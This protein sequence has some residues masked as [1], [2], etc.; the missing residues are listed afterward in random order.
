MNE[1]TEKATIATAIHV[2]KS[3]RANTKNTRPEPTIVDKLDGELQIE[4]SECPDLFVGFKTEG[5]A[6]IPCVRKG[7]VN[8]PVAHDIK[9]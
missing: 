5:M 3:L 9:P 8:G 4:V 6:K 1:T 2:L 7:S